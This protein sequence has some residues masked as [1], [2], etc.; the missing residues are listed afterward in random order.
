MENTDKEQKTLELATEIKAV[1]DKLYDLSEEWTKLTGDEGWVSKRDYQGAANSIMYD[2]EKRIVNI[3]KK[4]GDGSY[5]E[6]DEP[7][8][9]L[10]IGQAYWSWVRHNDGAGSECVTVVG[11]K[12]RKVYV[13]LW[14]MITFGFAYI[15]TR[16]VDG[17]EEKYEEVDLWWDKNGYTYRGDIA[18]WDTVEN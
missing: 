10:K 14:G 17:V 2:M 15:D 11:R 1:A 12:G 18:A 6:Y 4:C 9:M 8:Q 3:T 13:K 16:E 5:P 7:V